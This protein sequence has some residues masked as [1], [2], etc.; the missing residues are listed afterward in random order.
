MLTITRLTPQLYS[1]QVPALAAV[2]ADAVAGGASLGFRTPFGAGDAE[3]WWRAREDA[4]RDG[5]LTVWTASDPT[6]VV[7]TVSLAGEQKPNGRHRAEVLKL[8]VHRLARGRGV[9]RALLA[10]AE[11]AAAESGATLL[12]LDTETGSPAERLYA[13]AGWTRYGVVPG[14]A[15]SPDGTLEDCTFF[16]KPVT[17]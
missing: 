12:L 4:V 8:I 16:Y 11:R 7:G 14:Y 3:A 5:V 2:L 1:G 6:G 10:T 13:S 15:A 17:A 9:G